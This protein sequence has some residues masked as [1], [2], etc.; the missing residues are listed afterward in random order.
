MSKFSIDLNQLQL[1]INDYKK[2]IE[3][4]NQ[5]KSNLDNAVEE[6]KTSGW[7][8]GAST[9]YFSTFK[10]TWKT[11]MDMHIKILTHLEDCMVKAKVDYDSLYANIPNLGTDL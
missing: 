9:Q 6:L 4:F 5:L 7:V 8:S 1:T 3:D 11:N 10:E 2:S